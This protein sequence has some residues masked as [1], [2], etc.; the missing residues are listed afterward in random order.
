M[1]SKPFSLWKRQ[2]W[3]HTSNRIGYG[4]SGKVLPHCPQSRKAAN[5][6]CCR[7]AHN[8]AEPFKENNFGRLS[9]VAMRRIQQGCTKSVSASMHEVSAAAVSLKEQK[10]TRDHGLVDKRTAPV[11][12]PISRYPRPWEDLHT[13]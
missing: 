9:E 13:E 12:N 7:V 2:L 10:Q 8:T 4:V 5:I 6:Y 11:D 3:N 1:I